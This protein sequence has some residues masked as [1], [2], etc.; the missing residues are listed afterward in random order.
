MDNL[1]KGTQAES[2]AKFGIAGYWINLDQTH[3]VRIIYESN[4]ETRVPKINEKLIFLYFGETRPA[5][6]EISS[7]IAEYYHHPSITRKK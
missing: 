5:P 1:H 6:L 4:I 2:G 7:L 3:P